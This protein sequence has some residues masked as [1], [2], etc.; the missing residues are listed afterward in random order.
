LVTV[1]LVAGSA[2]AAMITN[3]RY[4]DHA[5][6]G[7]SITGTLHYG[8]NS[9][10]DEPFVFEYP[11][12]E[13]G[14]G[15]GGIKR[16]TEST[17]ASFNLDCAALESILAGPET[18]K[19]SFGPVGHLIAYPV[20]EFPGEYLENVDLEEVRIIIQGS[21]GRWTSL[22]FWVDGTA[23]ILA[24]EPSSAVLFGLCLVAIHSFRLPCR[25]AKSRQSRPRSVVV[26]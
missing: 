13:Q 17:A 20:R 25:R 1:V 23:A 2:E 10:G 19:V 5:H 3:S 4:F 26:E 12:P 14:L 8:I 6:E 11:I 15:L 9:E 21:L 22:T 18:K 7:N 16:I 24:P